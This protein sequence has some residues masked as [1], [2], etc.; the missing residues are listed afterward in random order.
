MILNI[1]SVFDEKAGAF[2]N[3]FTMQND[4]SAIR[5][6]TDVMHEGNHT[7]FRFASDYSLFSLGK[8][9]N[10]S[11][12]IIPENRIIVTLIQLRSSIITSEDFPLFPRKEA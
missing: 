7:F 3:P 11:G 5:A 1:Y 12:N 6:I 10:V 9:D 4:A 8:L 2:L